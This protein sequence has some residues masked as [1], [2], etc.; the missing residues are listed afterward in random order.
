MR[1]QLTLRKRQAGEPDH[2]TRQQPASMR[3]QLTL[4]KRREWVDGAVDDL[5]ASMRPQLTL[6]KRP[7]RRRA[8]SSSTR[9]FNEAAADAAEKA[10]D[11][12]ALHLPVAALQ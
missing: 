12:A 5:V 6:R 8:R 1:P 3:P 11:E 2:P 4:R 10:W 7:T 9:C